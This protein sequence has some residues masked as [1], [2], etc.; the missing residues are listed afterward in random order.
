MN[1]TTKAEQLAI[2][3]TAIKTIQLDEEGIVLNARETEAALREKH[4]VSPA[5]ARHWAAKA[6]RIA[7]G[8]MT[9][10]TFI[11]WRA[12]PDDLIIIERILEGSPDLEGVTSRAIRKALRYWSE[13]NPPA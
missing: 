12:T 4:G 10:T 5:R 3:A 8:K 2:L 11:A 6:S 7:R 13:Q 1:H 9:K